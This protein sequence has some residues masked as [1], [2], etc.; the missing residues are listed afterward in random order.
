MNP[1]GNVFDMHLNKFLICGVSLG[2]AKW[3]R[4]KP[5][6]SRR[7]DISIVQKYDVPK[8][9]QTCSKKSTIIC[10]VKLYERSNVFMQQIYNDDLG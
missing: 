4:N 3:W 7:H 8:C 10:V 2:E 1:Y 9:S 6:P 5:F